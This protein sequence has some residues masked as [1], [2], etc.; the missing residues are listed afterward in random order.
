MPITNREIYAA[1]E[2]LKPHKV[3]GLSGTPNVVLKKTR[4]MLVPYL[5]PIF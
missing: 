4:Y 5:G 3:L 2:R 1:V